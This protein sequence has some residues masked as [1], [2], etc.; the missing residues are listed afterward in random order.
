MFGAEPTGGEKN[1]SPRQRGWI[2]PTLE[3]NGIG[4]GYTGDGFKTVIPAKCIA[5]ISCRLCLIKTRTGLQ[6]L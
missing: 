4:G 5:K 1:Y 3:I 6:N 2:R